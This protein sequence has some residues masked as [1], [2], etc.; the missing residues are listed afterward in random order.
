[1][2]NR[3]NLSKAF[4]ELRKQGYFAKQNFMCCQSCAWAELSEGEAEK[5][6]FY[7][8]QDYR[9]LKSGDDLYLAWAGDGEFIVDTLVK[10]GMTISWDGTA[11]TR[12]LVRGFSI[13]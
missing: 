11:N 4:A 12:I 10:N 1:M 6:V 3:T 5:A 2:A 13:I 7:H 9:D 8:N